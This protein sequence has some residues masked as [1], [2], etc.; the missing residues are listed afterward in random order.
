MTPTVLFACRHNA[1][2]SQMAAALAGYHAGTKIRV[3]SAGTTPADDIHPLVSEVLKARGLGA[4]T[5]APRLL[6]AD[7]IAESDWVITMGC[8]ESC[9]VY[10]GKTYEDWPVD[11]PA[12]QSEDKVREIMADIERRVINLIERI[13]A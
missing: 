7:T 1:G 13:T 4:H 3:L 11:D 12:H 8:G 5:T 6:T 2:R 10:P 9:P